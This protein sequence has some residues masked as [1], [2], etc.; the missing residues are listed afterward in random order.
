LIADQVVGLSE[1]YVYDTENNQVEKY[2][3]IET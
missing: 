2:M 1:Y 3:E